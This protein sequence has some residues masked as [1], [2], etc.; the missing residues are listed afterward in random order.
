M[1]FS[2]FLI[3]MLPIPDFRSPGSRWDHMMRMGWPLTISKFIVSRA[4]SAEEE[5]RRERGK[6]GDIC[7]SESSTVY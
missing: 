1:E 4:L 7:D 6:S 3:K 5:A 2:K